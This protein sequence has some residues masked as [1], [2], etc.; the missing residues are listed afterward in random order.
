MAPS[1]LENPL[2]ILLSDV[3]KELLV[4]MVRRPD[5]EKRRWERGWTQSYFPISATNDIMRALG[6]IECMIETFSGSRSTNTDPGQTHNH[7]SRELS[8]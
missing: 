7:P 3:E 8:T 2:N 6:C 4:M 1:P 5:V